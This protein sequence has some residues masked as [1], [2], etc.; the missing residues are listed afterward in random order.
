MVKI[1]LDAGHGYNT[2]GKRTPDGIREW[3]MNDS[4]A[5]KVASALSGY[6]NVEVVRVDDPTGKTDISLTDR[7]N[8][9]K[10]INPD[11]FVSIHHNANTSNWGD[12]TGVEAYAH[13][14]APTLDKDLSKKFAERV[15]KK[16]GLKNRGAKLADFQVL[17]QCPVK[18]PGVLV[19][20]GFM[21]SRTD[22]PVI[23][24]SK[25]QQAYAD[26]V[27]E[28]IVEHFK[29]VKKPAPTP[30]P[31]TGTTYYRVI[32]GSYTN[33][34]TAEDVKKKLES[35]GHTGVWIDVFTK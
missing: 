26:A 21:D 27:V 11:L 14:S 33:K 4:V 1:V 35:Q 25:G 28:I 18:T 32:C 20:G 16:T 29:L 2:A 22:H 5:K 24:S 19:E 10:T 34:L 8:K 17:R 23:T 13:P 30:A 12:W 15:S 3:T 7:M 9:V 31:S 6:Q